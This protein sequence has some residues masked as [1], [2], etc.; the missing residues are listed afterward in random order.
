M[1][2]PFKFVRIPIDAALFVVRIE[3]VDSMIA[4][5]QRRHIRTAELRCGKRTVFVRWKG[6]ILAVKE[7]NVFCLGNVQTLTHQSNRRL[8]HDND[9]IAVLLCKI[10]RP[11]C[12]I[13]QLL[14][15]RRTDNDRFIVAAG[16]VAH[17]IDIRLRRVVFTAAALHIGHN[18][19][20][21][22]RVAVAE[23]FLHIVVAGTCRC[24]HDL[25]AGERSTCAGV[26]GA[27]LVLALHELTADLRKSL[28]HALGNFICRG[29]GIAAEEIAARA[30]R[31]F[32]QRVVAQHKVD[33]GIHTLFPHGKL[34]CMN[35]WHGSNSFP[36]LLS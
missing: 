21:F 4:L 17:L 15:G 30:E 13:I 27:E 18:N 35:D 25:A 1:I 2:E 16:A 11:N 10:E 6:G 8:G 32:D 9:R 34:I 28:A 14:H 29:D 19:R 20:C 12:V 23:T 5:C 36:V 24:G 33:A 26:D 3:R 7:F 22:D 31:S